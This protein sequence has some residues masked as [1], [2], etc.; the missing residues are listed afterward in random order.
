MHIVGFASTNQFGGHSTISTSRATSAKNHTG[1]MPQAGRKSQD[2]ENRSGGTTWPLVPLTKKARKIRLGLTCGP[3]EVMT[4]RGET[5]VVY[6]GRGFCSMRILAPKA[7][8][9]YD[10]VK[11]EVLDLQFQFARE[12]TN[13]TRTGS[14]FN[15]GSNQTTQTSALRTPNHKALQQKRPPLS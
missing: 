15:R 10:L 8:A 12:E 3:K 1:N 11:A 14:Q 4:A 9:Q 5:V 6:F 7:L 13:A 2:A